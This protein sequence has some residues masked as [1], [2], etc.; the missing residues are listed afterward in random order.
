MLRDYFS[1]GYF[2]FRIC[3]LFSCILRGDTRATQIP[4]TLYIKSNFQSN[5]FSFVQSIY[6]QL[7]PFFTSKF[8]SFRNIF[9]STLIMASC[10]KNHSPL[11]VFRFHGFQVSGYSFLCHISIKPPPPAIYPINSF[12][13]LKMGFQI[14]IVN[15]FTCLDLSLFCILA[16][17]A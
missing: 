1:S 4:T 14:I 9:I 8:R 3:K 13:F 2:K 7:I 5:S 11:K 16:T 15:V 12:R 17:T 10:I 6:K